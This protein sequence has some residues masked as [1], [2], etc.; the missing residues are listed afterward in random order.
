MGLPPNTPVK[1]QIDE[2]IRRWD[3]FPVAPER[4][5]NPAW[6]ENTV[7]GEA[8]NLFDILPLFRLNDGDGGFY[9]D[10]ACVVSRD[11]LDPDHFGKQNVGIYRMEVKGKRKLGLQPVPMHDIALHLHKAEERG[12]DLPIAITLGNDPIITLMGA[13]PLKYDQSE[14]EMAGALRE[15]P[16]PIATAPLTGFDVPELDT[17]YIDKP[18]QKHNLIQTISR[19]NRKLEGKSKGLVVDYIGIKRQMNQALAMYS[20]IDAT[21]FEDIQQS[22]IEVKNHLDL[23]AQVFHEFDSS[24][25]FSGEPQAQLACLNNA[26]EFV[27]RTQKVERRFMG[28]VKRLKAAYDV[29]CGSEALSQAERDHIH[30]YLAVRSIVFKLTK[31]DAPDVTQMNA[32]VREMIAEALK[33]DG[34]EEL[35][36]L[37]DKK[38][39]SIDIFDNDYLDR[40]NK[41][42]LPATKIQLLQKLLEKAISDFKQINQLQG[43]NFTRRFQSIMDKYNERR[44]DDVLNGEEFD[45]FSQE[46]T[47][48]IYDIKTEMGTYAEMGIDIEEK[49]FYDILA[50]MRDKYQ[51][52][53]EDDKMLGLAKEMKAVVDNTS[54]YPDWSKRDDIKA[55]LKVELILLLHKHKFPPVANDDVYMGV[56]VQAENFKQHHINTV[57]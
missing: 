7:D 55:K 11:P 45:T 53:Y 36:F 9:L 46:M 37:G 18:L 39:E 52:T 16:Y 3:K 13:T 14:Y 29:C 19:V 50:H 10:K 42:K 47:D 20:R 1:K 15:S 32:R 4:R 25:Y 12:Q 23:L 5:D 54:K 8:I 2:F 22:V 57:H 6:A 21:N 26:A 30:F 34:V 49:A 31:G 28:L 56:L 33:A 48:I 44:E 38:A 43:I 51:F 40:I 24:A 41:I 27:M 17:I 35:F